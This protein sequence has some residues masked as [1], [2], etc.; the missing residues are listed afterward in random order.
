MNDP[1]DEIFPRADNLP[2]NALEPIRRAVRLVKD[3]RAK[4]KDGARDGLPHG[5]SRIIFR[6]LIDDVRYRRDGN[7]REHEH[8]DHG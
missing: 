1:R 5:V 8:D 2:L 4:D 7:H 6:L 3:A